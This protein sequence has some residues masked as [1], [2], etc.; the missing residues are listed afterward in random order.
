MI[1]DMPSWF[2]REEYI[3]TVM[4]EVEK[5]GRYFADAVLPMYK[6]IKYGGERAEK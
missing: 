2:T 4:G 3:Q 6:R 1:T 5:I